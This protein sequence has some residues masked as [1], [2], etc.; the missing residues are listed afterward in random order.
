MKKYLRYGFLL[1]WSAFAAG[2]ADTWLDVVPDND[3]ETIETNFEKKEDAEDWLKTCYVFMTENC[4]EATNSANPAN[5]GA[6]EICGNEYARN[7]GLVSLFIGDG[8]QMAQNPYGN[9]WHKNQYYAA[10]RYCN[11]FLENIGNVY[12]MDDE[13]KR[14]WSAEVKAVKAFYYFDLMR[15]YGP[16]ILMDENL[17]PNMPVEDMLRS[18]RPIDE[19]VDA[20]VSLCD[21]AMR[22]LPYMSGKEETHKLYFNKEATATLKALTLLY[23]ASPLFNGNTMFQD[24]TNRDGEKCFPEYDHEKWRVAAEACD[25]AILICKEAGKELVSGS[26]NRPSSMLNT[27]MDIERTWI[28]DD[29]DSKEGILIVNNDNMDDGLALYLTPAVDPQNTEYYDNYSYGCLS[30]PIKMVE[31][32]YTEHGLPID[33]DNQWMVN[34]YQMSKEY[35]RRYENVVPLGE[36]VLSLHLRREPRFYATIIYD[37]AKYHGDTFEM[38]VSEDGTSW[39]IDNYR[40]SGDNPMGNYVLRKFMPDEN[41]TLSWQTT[42]TIPWIFFRLGEIYL[43]YAEAEFELGHEDV[44]RT[45]LNKVRGRVS[46]PDIPATVTGE[47]LKKRIYNERRVELAF[48]EH[49]YFDLRRWKLAMEIENR[50]IYGVT[51]TKD[52]GNPDEN[53]NKTYK[54]ELLLERVFKPEMYLL[55]IA[56]D[57]IRKNDGKLLQTP[58]WRE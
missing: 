45:Y 54:D 41:T 12:N 23:A 20:I 14:L 11:I 56:T 58:T 32:F 38:W 29:Y 27:M 53:T 48:E 31:M 24:F 2:C 30:A 55:P 13:E 37:G 33:E 17:D 26:S 6:D 25:S 42:Y 5:L 47:D 28:G 51:I 1:V 49:R 16:I 3:I 10:I 40:Q 9:V 50:P 44:C 7:M 36:D 22:D 52:T 21:E 43:N 57:E 39:G 4:A 15:R 8:L 46:M 18:R 19:V 35:D 34:R